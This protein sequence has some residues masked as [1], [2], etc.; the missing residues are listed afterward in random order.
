MPTSLGYRSPKL[1]GKSMAASDPFNPRLALKFATLVFLAVSNTG[2]CAKLAN[3]GP[4]IWLG[5]ISYSLY[6]IHG[7]IQFMASKGL[8]ALGIQHTAALSSGQS[9]ALMML[10]LALCIFCAS[11][12]YTG[13]E[14]IWR[15]QLRALLGVGQKKS[16]ARAF[17]SQRA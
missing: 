11:A 9:L 15:R 1:W 14:V 13:V 8:G 6:L 17:G 7:L 16:S 2:T 3:T 12:T 10:M 5:E 4:L